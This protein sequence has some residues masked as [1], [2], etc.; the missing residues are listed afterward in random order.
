M[1]RLRQKAA[2]SE[3]FIVPED[4][5]KDFETSL[6][7]GSITVQSQYDHDFRR[8]G[9]T[10]ARGDAVAREQMRDVVITLQKVI[11]HLREVF[12]DDASLDLRMLKETS[13]DS[14]VNATVCL[15]QLYQRMS[16]AA[17]SMKEM[18]RSYCGEAEQ[19]AASNTLAYSSS[20]STNSS[21][22]GT[23][24]D[25][26][27]S[28]SFASYSTRTAVEGDRK[29]SNGHQPHRRMS[30][31][32]AFSYS[33]EREPHKGL[34]PEGDVML[35][36]PPPVQ[37]HSSQSPSLDPVG[38][39][40]NEGMNMGD[41]RAVMTTNS[42]PRRD[43]PFYSL[44]LTPLVEHIH[45]AEEAD[46]RL[47]PT[48]S[49]HD[50]QSSG[51]SSPRIPGSLTNTSQVPVVAASSVLKPDNGITSGTIA[52]LE[53]N[54]QGPV[55]VPLN[56]EYSTL[57]CVVSA[58]GEWHSLPPLNPQGYMQGCNQ[59]TQP[60]WLLSHSTWPT[61]QGEPDPIYTGTYR[62]ALNGAGL[63]NMLTLNNPVPTRVCMMARGMVH[64][65]RSQ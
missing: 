4:L 12:M 44:G 34:E 6:S 42:V 1:Q 55:P 35:K 5:I 54:Q 16:T 19:Q 13:D 26:R 17:A 23:P 40:L 8:F 2:T 47:S 22:G 43:L 39:S 37:R 51:R 49:G 64:T 24:W 58:G 48:T 63:V 65:E 31:T 7:L 60:S 50:I 3:E 25:S 38:K 11:T 56:P 53:V 32:S 57:E 28:T 45:D 18:S 10:Y 9:E 30:L 21:T 27:S 52:P 41:E 46:L 59:Q 29:P 36:R 20:Q 15:G 61:A 14:R 33:S 62:P